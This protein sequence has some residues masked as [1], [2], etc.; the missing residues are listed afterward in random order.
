M[1]KATADIEYNLDA[2]PE[3]Y[4]NSSVHTRLTSYT[5]VARSVY[6]PSYDLSTEDHL[7]PQLVMRV[8]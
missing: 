6:G 7:D 3:A 4:T 8:G 5:G 1:G 2:L